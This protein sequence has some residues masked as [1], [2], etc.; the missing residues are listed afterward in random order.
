[1]EVV[2]EQGVTGSEE[3]GGHPSLP[4]PFFTPS[5]AW[6]TLMYELD[7]IKRREGYGYDSRMTLRDLQNAWHA[8]IGERSFWLG[9]GG[10]VQV[11]LYRDIYPHSKPHVVI[12]LLT[13]ETSISEDSN[14]FCTVEDETSS[15]EATLD[16][17]LIREQGT[18]L[19]PG[20]CLILFQPALFPESSWN[21]NLIIHPSRV[22]KIRSPT[23]SPPPLPSQD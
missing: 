2:E 12:R 15:M 22:A 4:V 13:L 20:T 6:T 7:E 23:D 16:Y 21:L 10:S 19:G 14:A 11:P 1:M 3:A 17:R 8:S 18:R 9:G 5:A